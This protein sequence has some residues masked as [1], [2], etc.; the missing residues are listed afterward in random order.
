[1]ISWTDHVRNEVL[2]TVKEQRNILHKT[3]KRKASASILVQPTDITRTQY[4]KCQRHL[5]M[6]K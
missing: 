3:S 5:R 4:T 1:M 2:L 6:S